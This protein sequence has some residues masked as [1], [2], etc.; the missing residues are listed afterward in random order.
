MKFVHIQGTPFELKS[1]FNLKVNKKKCLEPALS[2]TLHL[3]KR[4]ESNP[5]LI[6]LIFVIFG[7]RPQFPV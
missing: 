6:K 4:N 1:Q 3:C 2:P 5:L 7:S